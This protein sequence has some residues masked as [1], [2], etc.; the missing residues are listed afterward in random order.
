MQSGRVNSYSTEFMEYSQHRR[1]LT[2]FCMKYFFLLARGSTVP[3]FSISVSVTCPQYYC[4]I[5][6]EAKAGKNER[7]RR[8][9]QHQL[10]TTFRQCTAGSLDE[11]HPSGPF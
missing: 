5:T 10:T 1:S 3:R 8:K 2:A 4:Y 7:L 11:L 6:E 9:E